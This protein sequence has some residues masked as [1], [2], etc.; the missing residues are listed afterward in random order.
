VTADAPA[1]IGSP[2]MRLTKDEI[3]I[4]ARRIARLAWPVVLTSLNWTIMHMIDVAVVGH[5]GTGEL[6]DLSAGRVLTF[7]LMVV[8]FSSLTGILVF[9]SRADGAGDHG[10]TGRYLRAGLL[11]ALVLAVPCSAAL[12]LFSEELLRAVQVAPTMIEGGAAV[13]RAMALSFPCYFLLQASAMF[14]EGISRPRPVAM[15]NLMMLPLNAVLAWAWVG[16][17]LGLPAM[18]AVGA[19]LA[20]AVISAVGSVA[21]FAAAWTIPD[22]RARGVHDLGIAAWVRA[23]RDV[24]MLLRFGLMPG[25][26]AGL[27]IGGFAILMVLTTQLGAVTAAAFQAVFSLHNLAFALALGFGSAAGVRSGNAVGEGRPELA[28]PRTLIACALAALAMLA[29]GLVFALFARPFV[30]PFSDDVAVQMLAAG[31]LVLL[32]PFMFLD[33]IQ[34]VAVY[35]LRSLGDQVVAGVNGIVAYFLVTGSVALA[36]VHAGAGAIGLIWAVIA[37]MIA[38]AALQGGR[39]WWVISAPRRRP[40]PG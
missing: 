8:G 3:R 5:A 11:L 9:A 1:A 28:W 22:A 24:P 19:V 26:A 25:I 37:G 12:L 15:V 21:M 32:G 16:G 23:A 35:A 30:A 18:G 31:M 40:V 13:A 10:S 36:L 39:L 33:G 14:L 38:A 17:H 7:A 29:A 2:A 6:A 20:T 34:V 27:E 4:E